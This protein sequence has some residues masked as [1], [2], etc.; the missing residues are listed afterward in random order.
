MINV[1]KAQRECDWSIS[2]AAFSI[3]EARYVAFSSVSRSGSAPFSASCQRRH[4]FEEKH[5]CEWRAHLTPS[6]SL[7]QF[8]RFFLGLG[9]KELAYRSSGRRQFG[10]VRFEFVLELF[11]G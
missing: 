7:S 4:R 3:R 2:R 8:S 1:E 5:M 10:L 9:F 6:R 11:H